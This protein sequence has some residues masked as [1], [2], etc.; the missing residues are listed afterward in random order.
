MTK[1]VVR[2]TLFAVSENRV[3]FA[4]L[5]ELFFRVGIVGIAIGMVLQRQLAIGAFDL[6]IGCA[7][8]YAQ[9]F[10]VIAFYVAGQNGS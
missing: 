10:V 8:G 7:P 6:L 2:R 4:A 5:F 9:D 3:G 1:A